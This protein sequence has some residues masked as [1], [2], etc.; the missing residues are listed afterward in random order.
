MMDKIE[1]QHPNLNNKKFPEF[2]K[3]LQGKYIL[4]LNTP[5]V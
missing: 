2:I 3:F 5:L 1:E 4:P